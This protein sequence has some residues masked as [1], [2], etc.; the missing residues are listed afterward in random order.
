M[1]APASGDADAPGAVDRPVPVAGYEVSAG[2]LLRTSGLGS[3][4]GIA[5]H[6]P[7]AAVGGLVHPMLPTRDGA[8]RTPAR[9]VDTGVERLLDA[10]V[11]AGADRGRIVARMA[12]GATVVSFNWGDEDAVGERNAAAAEAVLEDAG[13]A[14]VGRDLGGD[15][16]RSM[17]FD[18]ATGELTVERTDGV[19]TVL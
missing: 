9:Y 18:T 14:V 11:A 6:D 7:A 10:V 17:R 19:T 2:G 8:D 4:L 13:V 5:L 12:G 16:G 3:C 15:N 1:A